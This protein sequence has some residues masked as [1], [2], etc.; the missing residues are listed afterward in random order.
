MIYQ[1]KNGYLQEK[2]K[3]LATTEVWFPASL[4]SLNLQT[5]GSFS[6]Q[7]DALPNANPSNDW[8]GLNMAA[9]YSM[10]FRNGPG[11][12]L[13]YHFTSPNGSAWIQELSWDQADDTWQTGA[14]FPGA[15]PNSHLAATVDEQH[16]AVRVFYCI[17][18]GTMQESWSNIT[19]ANGTYNLGKPPHFV[20]SSHLPS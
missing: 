19:Q 17:G 4:N 11:A 6:P 7:P 8:D 14:A 18:N 9:V 16:K 1:G 12:R 10:N 15:S 20:V 2:R 3:K 13:Y 5:N